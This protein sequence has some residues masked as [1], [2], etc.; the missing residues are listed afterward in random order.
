MK[1]YQQ[2]QEAI[3]RHSKGE[4][5][6]TIAQ[7]MNKSRKWVHH[8]IKRYKNNPADLNWFKDE[9]RAPKKTNSLLG[10]DIESQILL[11]RK[12]LE[13]YPFNMNASAGV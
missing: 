7:A 6:T 4:K 1:E 5:I 13:L 11:I 10:T 9:S 12:E 2:R 3:N 8:W